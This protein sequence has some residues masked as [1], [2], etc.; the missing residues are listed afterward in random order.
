[1]NKMDVT[2]TKPLEKTCSKC[3]ETKSNDK[4]IPKRNICKSCRNERSRDKYKNLEPPNELDEKCNC[5]N[6]EKPIS[7]FIKNRKICKDCNNEKR[8]FKYENDEEHR[9]KIIESSTIFK[10]NKIIERKKIKK[11]EIG[12]DNKKCNYCNEIKEQNKFRNNR[13]KCK[14]C[15]RNE[16]LEKMK[17]TIRSR[18]ISAINNKEKHTVEYLGCTVKDYLKWL[19]NN[20]NGF[21]LEN[22]GNQWHIDHVI[23]L[24]HFDLENKEEQMVAFNWRNT[25]ALSCKENLSKNKKILNPQIEQHLKKL[26]EYHTEN[27]LDLPQVFIDLFAKHLVAG[28][29]LEPVLFNK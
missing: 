16:P 23:P 4:F 14:D 8:K 2:D 17:R 27:K 6:K 3:G 18:I 10:K 25:T 19:L 15:E 24:F 13:L 11:E 5:C 12:I 1:M 21:V 28:T 9:K 7:S 22:R 29:P 20:D 26:K